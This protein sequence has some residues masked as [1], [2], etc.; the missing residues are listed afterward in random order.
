MTDFYTI[1]LPRSRSIW[2]STLLAYGDSTTFH[3]NLSRHS[4]EIRPDVST[5]YRGFCD[6]NPLIE[7]DYG[8]SPVLIVKRPVEDVIQSCLDCFDAPVGVTS[9]YDFL[10]NYAGMYAT[11]LD[12]L[13][14]KNSLIVDYA[15]IN[16][17]AVEICEFLMP[18]NAIP[19]EFIKVM[20]GIRVQTTNRELTEALMDTA[21]AEGTT[22][23]KYIERFDIPTYRCERIYDVGIAVTTMSAMWDAISEDG[24]EQYQPDVVGELWIGIYTPTE[25]VGMYRF[26]QLS[27]VLWQ[28]HTFMLPDK[29]MH[30]LGGGKAMLS[31][32]LDNIPT[33]RKLIVEIPECYPNVVKFAENLGFKLQGFNPDSFTKNGLIGVHQYGITNEEMKWSQQQ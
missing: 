17:R 19:A 2:F 28:G 33:L 23:K 10:V 12:A 20:T 5:K 13:K 22:Y 16:D 21:K 24:V 6:T 27:S 7:V 14:P 25:Y 11:A 9:Y 4:G 29:R 1:G 15:D 31:W 26:H 8:D 32:I 30:S 3:E 18:D